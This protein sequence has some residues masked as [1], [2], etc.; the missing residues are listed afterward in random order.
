MSGKETGIDQQDL[1][2]SCIDTHSVH[3]VREYI[4]N[5]SLIIQG[6]QYKRYV[7]YSNPETYVK[8]VKYCLH[9]LDILFPEEKYLF[10]NH[11]T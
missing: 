2:K 11:W 8:A 10:G 3:L 1:Y 5:Q 7:Y 6:E 4:L 9:S